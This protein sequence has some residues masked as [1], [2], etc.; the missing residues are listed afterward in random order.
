MSNDNVLDKMLYEVE[1]AAS[2]I[3]K[4]TEENAQL[5]IKHLQEALKESG[6]FE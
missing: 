5:A 2:A 6:N 3:E 4:P 1:Q